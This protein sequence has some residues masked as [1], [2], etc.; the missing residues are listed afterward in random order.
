MTAMYFSMTGTASG[1][2]SAPAMFPADTDEIEMWNLLESI[3][4]VSEWEAPN[5]TCNGMLGHFPPTDVVGRLCSPTL[6]DIIE[7]FATD[8][9]WLPATIQNKGAEHHY[10][11][12]HF[13]TIPDVLDLNKSEFV[14][15][16]LFRPCFAA[17]RVI[18]YKVFILK[19]TTQLVYVHTDVR[20]AIKKSGIKGLN[21]EKA[22][23][24]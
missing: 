17:D 23:V 16:R 8:A 18:N 14:S 3:T 19:K 7:S 21:F 15:G 10:F 4:D 22:D 20:E 9:L 5:L 1:K 2:Y 24:L 11:F 12:L 13:S 6:R